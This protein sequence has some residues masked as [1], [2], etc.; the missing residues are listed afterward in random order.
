MNGRT[1]AVA[2]GAGLPIRRRHQHLMPG[3]DVALTPFPGHANHV[4]AVQ[5][6]LDY[7][8]E[9][10]LCM[11]E[12]EQLTIKVGNI[13]A[14]H[15][16]PSGA[17]HDRRVWV[18]AIAFKAGEEVWSHGVLPVDVP[19]AQAPDEEPFSFFEHAFDSNGDDA[20]MFWDAQSSEHN[21]LVAPSD[22]NVDSAF[23]D[24]HQFR[25]FDLAGLEVDAI[26]I[27]VKMRPMAL[28]VIQSLIDSGDLDPSVR[29]AIPTFTLKSTEVSWT[30][31]DGFICLPY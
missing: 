21:L 28:H 18:E 23:A 29:A 13:G 1:E 7:A 25:V 17:A 6:E 11:S 14:G 2:S 15:S 19:L 5:E 30:R 20:L 8:L 26:E 10:H 9:A 31:A 22:L 4:A 16:F 12:E 3:V 27:K 24:Q